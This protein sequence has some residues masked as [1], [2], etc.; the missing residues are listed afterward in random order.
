MK[1]ESREAVQTTDNRYV[2]LAALTLG[3]AGLLPLLPVVGSIAAIICGYAA[4]PQ[5]QRARAG[6]LLGWFGLLAVTTALLLYCVVLGY[7]FPIHR[8]HPGP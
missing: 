3:I 4:G 5:D 8:Y 2:G 1:T 7:P 6:V